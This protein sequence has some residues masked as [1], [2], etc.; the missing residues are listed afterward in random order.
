M[1]E[2]SIVPGCVPVV[3]AAALTFDGRLFSLP[4]TGSSGHSSVGRVVLAKALGPI[5]Y[6]LKSVIDPD[7]PLPN[8][9]LNRI[10]AGMPIPLDMPELEIDLSQQ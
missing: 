3:V 7:A 4:R 2:C 10:R 8:F 1:F 6:Q 9:I 5:S